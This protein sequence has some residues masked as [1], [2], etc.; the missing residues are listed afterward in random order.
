[1]TCDK[2][3][4]VC[5]YCNKEINFNDYEEHLII[6]GSKTVKCPDCGTYVKNSEMRDHK[7]DGLCEVIAE[8]KRE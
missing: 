8:Q 3:P 4:I 5:K 2:K 1:M 7:A 6:C